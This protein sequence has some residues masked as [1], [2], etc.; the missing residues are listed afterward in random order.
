MHKE[1]QVWS[2]NG[3]R[4]TLSHDEN[5]AQFVMFVHVQGVKELCFFHNLLQPLTFKALNAMRVY[6]LISW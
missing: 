4:R 5:R 2:S 3:N 1:E 6:T